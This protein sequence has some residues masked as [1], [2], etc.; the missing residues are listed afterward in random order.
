MKSPAKKLIIISI[1]GLKPA[2]KFIESINIAAS[3]PY[4]D[5]AASNIKISK[6]N[7]KKKIKLF[8]INYKMLFERPQ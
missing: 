3:D 4:G 8:D 5:E 2:L 1:S 6:K 7:P